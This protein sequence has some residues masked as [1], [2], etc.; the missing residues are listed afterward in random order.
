MPPG[1]R[2]ERI[3]VARRGIV[4]GDKTYQLTILSGPAVEARAVALETV[5]NDGRQ[6]HEDLVGLDPVAET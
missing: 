2:E 1:A 6:P 3:D 5:E 4:A